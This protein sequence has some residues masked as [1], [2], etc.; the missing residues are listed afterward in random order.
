MGF[1]SR[2]SPI[3]IRMSVFFVTLQVVPVGRNFWR[4]API[5]ATVSPW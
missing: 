2:S 4:N 5:S 1:Q 3:A